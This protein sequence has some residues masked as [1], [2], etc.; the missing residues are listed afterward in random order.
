MT[1]LANSKE[2]GITIVS[3]RAISTVDRLGVASFYYGLGLIVLLFGEML[4]FVFVDTTRYPRMNHRYAILSTWAVTAVL[5]PLP[6][7][8]WWRIHLA[9]FRRRLYS[10]FLAAGGLGCVPW[11]T[12]TIFS[13]QILF[14]DGSL[15]LVCQ[16]IF[17]GVIGIPLVAMVW[18]LLSMLAWP[19]IM[20]LAPFKI[21]DGATCPKCGYCVRGVASRICP[22]CGTV[23]DHTQLGLSPAAFDRLV[24]GSSWT[25]ANSSQDESF[26]KCMSQSEP[27]V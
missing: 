11:L 8:F 15:K 20:R 4:V 16:A 12:S 24:A 22:E 6:A 27:R 21:Q 7:L 3:R 9:T 25:H 5:G 17:S 1:I 18:T 26:R 13:I 14:D 10:S 2:P 23:F 19:I